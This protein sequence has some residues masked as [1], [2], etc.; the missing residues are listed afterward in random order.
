MAKQLFR[1]RRLV[2]QLV[3]M[4]TLSVTAASLVA[5]HSRPTVTFYWEDNSDKPVTIFADE[6]RLGVSEDS[7]IVQCAGGQTVRLERDGFEDVK[8]VIQPQ[9]RFAKQRIRCDWKK[10]PVQN[11]IDEASLLR[12]SALVEQSEPRL[13]QTSVHSRAIPLLREAQNLEES[14][15]VVDT[16]ADTL[17]LQPTLARPVLDSDK[18][19][20]W[21]IGDDRLRHSGAV[22]RILFTPDGTRIVSCGDDGRIGLFDAATGNRI[23][24]L[25]VH[26]SGVTTLAI[27]RNSRRLISGDYQGRV[28]KWNLDNVQSTEMFRMKGRVTC[29]A[30]HPDSTQTALGS[31]TNEL[32]IL[33]TTTHEVIHQITLSDQPT[34]VAFANDGTRLEVACRDGKVYL[35]AADNLE[36]LNAFRTN[37]QLEHLYFSSDSRRITAVG[38]RE[39]TTWQIKTGKPTLEHKTAPHVLGFASDGSWVSERRS[40][41]KRFQVRFK[42]KDTESNHELGAN[43]PSCVA[44][45]DETVAIG[46]LGGAVFIRALNTD[47]PIA[48][49]T[50]PWSNWQHIA[51][52]QEAER[53]A[54]ATSSGRIEVIDLRSR[55]SVF[56]REGSGEQIQRLFLASPSNQLIATHPD[57]IVL[58]SLDE[59]GTENFKATSLAHLSEDGQTLAYLR[60][61]SDNAYEIVV[62]DLLEK[63]D[64]IKI[65][66][67][68][69][70]TAIHVVP[71]WRLLLVSDQDGKVVAYG[72]KK[73]NRR[74][75]LRSPVG[76]PVNHVLTRGSSTKGKIYVAH[77]K[78][79]VTW[80]VKKFHDPDILSIS[81]K[82]TTFRCTPFGRSI[83]FASNG[84]IWAYSADQPVRVVSPAALSASIDNFEVATGEKFCVVAAGNATVHIVP[85]RETKQVTS[86]DK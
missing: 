79:I 25:D 37:R 27:S 9:G 5:I 42:F 64:T 67:E 60:P 34:D 66:V 81:G 11:L 46:T 17:R 65:S 85:L 76:S 83:W 3:M 22:R 62:R 59:N 26:T 10:T 28:R 8:H 15:A 50:P 6:Q 36:Q 2:L 73:G 1:S 43:Q 21:S 82:I 35:Y 33:D 12:E 84:S 54:L 13:R 72:L 18:P 77:D 53:L 57:E 40:T 7:A 23:Q 86:Q 70:L 52:D 69:R 32:V 19:S 16:L 29:A 14:T 30:I 74:W 24:Y 51:L 58:Y 20:T 61:V 4:A 49:P 47:E 45:H 31:G 78:K 80:Q 55:E 71:H 39:S 75:A 68:N 63:T 56:S 48:S 41:G 38:E 44:L